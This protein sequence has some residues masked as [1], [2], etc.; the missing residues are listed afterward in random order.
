M[1]NPR[2][3]T[4]AMV[5][6]LLVSGATAAM[7]QDTVKKSTIPMTSASSGQEMFNTYCAVCHGTSGKGD[8]PAS[9]EFKIAPANLT[10][11]AKN[12][13]GTFP[14]AYVSQVIQTGPRDAKAHGSKDMP[15]WGRLFASLGDD[16][17]VKLRVHNLTT[18]IGSLQA[19]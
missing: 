7:A 3:R 5:A 13:N 16:A 2:I 17:T 9:S 11:L 10:M 18:Y 8:G 15:V 6:A 4:A 14:E 1:M 12:H 19:K